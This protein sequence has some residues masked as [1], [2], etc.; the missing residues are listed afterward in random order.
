LNDTD[1][2]IDLG[3][4][5]PAWVISGL[6]HVVILTLFLLIGVSQAT[7]TIATDSAIVMESATEEVEKKDNFEN[8]D[9]GRL[10]DLEAGIAIDLKGDVN[11]P[12]PPK[13]IEAPG[14][15]DSQNLN[16]MDMTPPPGFDRGEGG[17]IKDPNQS[18]PG[19]PLD[20]LP[21]GWEG[22]FR[23]GDSAGRTGMTK[24]FVLG[25]EGGNE[26]SE[27][28]VAIGLSWLRRHQF[29]DGHWSLQNFHVAGHCNCTG[30]AGAISYANDHA[31]T[32]L[33]LL[34]F[35]G[36]G[37]THKSGGPNAKL[38]Q[39][40][41]DWM[42]A[43]QDNKNIDGALSTTGYAH[44]L[45]T[46]C[47]CEAYG[48]TADPQLRVPAQRAL[49]ACVNWQ[50]TEGG[51]RYDPRQPG[52]LSVSGWFI[53]ALKSGQM[54]GLNVP[55]ATFVGVNSYLDSVSTPD[56]SQYRYISG[57]E[58][59]P[60]MTSVGLLSR[61]YMGW[62]TKA[63]GLIKGVEVL[64]RQPPAAG[65]RDMYYYYYATQA[66][67]NM[68]GDDWKQWNERMRDMLID[69]QDQGTTANRADQKGSWSAEGDRWGSGLGRLGYTSLSLL[70]LE[71][72]YRH[73]PLY[74]REMGSQKDPAVRNALQ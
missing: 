27:R 10:A 12:A 22:I 65:F 68:G 34:P 6:A 45:C 21:G 33:G 63:P 72:Y 11:V 43:H 59:S 7:G 15:A 52:D 48:L 26:R 1:E 13:P 35:L 8:E 64:K 2:G 55:Q 49:N 56:M 73:L 71:V 36:A 66:M 47:L 5:L 54:A 57:M 25:Q 19:N 62:G 61:Q 69:A 32:A 30:A 39:T 41:L 31:A 38:V 44:A 14:V 9:I 17:F 40:A 51:F 3:R 29:N 24:A 58:T 28:A 20:R 53:Q 50:H 42:I 67:H 46:I 23:K 60:A 70:T 37:Y 18:G 74:R 4:L 16:P